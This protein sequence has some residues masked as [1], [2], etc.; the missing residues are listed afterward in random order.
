MKKVS[1]TPPTLEGP[2]T[3]IWKGEPREG[4]HATIGNWMIHAP[5]MH[6]FWS[7]HYLSLVHLREL[8][9]VSPP[10]MQFPEATHEF[11][12]LALNPEHEPDWG[13]L[14]Y[15]TPPSI[16]QQFI[17]ENDAQALEWIEL[18]LPQIAEG[19]LSVDSDFRSTWFHFLREHKIEDFRQA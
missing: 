9:G 3:K 1:D 14:Y 19:E 16:T 2:N 5:W 13:K 18:I 11:L 6:P 17:A 15:L 10:N 4:D 8:D 7:W 12:V